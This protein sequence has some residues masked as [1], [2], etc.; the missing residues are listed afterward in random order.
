M[1]VCT[2]VGAESHRDPHCQQHVAM[3]L[4]QTPQKQTLKN[5]HKHAG[6]GFDTNGDFCMSKSGVRAS[7][8]QVLM[9]N[10]LVHTSRLVGLG[11]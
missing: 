8:I 3:G 4:T 5:A 7:R 1:G 10:D 9:E 2:F 6:A 11:G